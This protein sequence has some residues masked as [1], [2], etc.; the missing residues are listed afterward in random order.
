MPSFPAR[1]PRAE[2]DFVL[3]SR[4][5]DILDFRIPDVRLSD[6][7]PVVCDFRVLSAQEIAARER[8]SAPLLA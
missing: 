8:H 2:L 3:V 7:R 1:I 6:H 4:E 5:I